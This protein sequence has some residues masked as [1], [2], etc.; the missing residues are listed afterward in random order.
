MTALA[1]ASEPSLKA[2]TVNFA[3]EEKVLGEV[4][5][6]QHL[7]FCKII[8]Y[9]VTPLESLMFKF[10]SELDPITKQPIILDFKSAHFDKVPAGTGLFQ[11]AAGKKLEMI[12]NKD[13]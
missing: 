3:G 9:D 7:S 6:S 12:K 1:R 8:R 13:E 11:L 5:R 2:C 10:T 4:F